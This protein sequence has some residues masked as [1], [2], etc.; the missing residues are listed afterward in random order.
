MSYDIQISGWGSFLGELRRLSI[1][2]GCYFADG[3]RVLVGSPGGRPASL[4]FG[5]RVFVNHYAV[6]DAAFSIRIGSNVLI[7]PH[8]YIGDFDHAPG[9]EGSRGRPAVVGGPVS[10]GDD[11]WIGAG[12]VVLKGVTIGRGAVIGAGCV[13]TKDIPAGA[14]VVGD[15]PLRFLNVPCGA[16]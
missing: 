10:I 12:A 1:G 7:G 5:S 9:P 16:S 3:A 11:V 13:V 15:A 6:I 4:S 2:R 8:A 14:T